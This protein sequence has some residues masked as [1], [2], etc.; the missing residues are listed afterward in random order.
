MTLKE[1]R[2]SKNLTQLSV[3]R[4]MGVKQCTVS[5]LETGTWLNVPMLERYIDALGGV[6]VI[7]IKYSENEVELKL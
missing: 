4:R 5:K 7:K 2:R 6:L 1:L 3:A